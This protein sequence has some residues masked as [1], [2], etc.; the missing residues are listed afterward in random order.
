MITKK[1]ILAIAA[2]QNVNPVIIEKDYVLG[3]MLAGISVH[4]ILS[5]S[6][7]F[8][9]GTCIKKCYFGEY[10][11]SE[12]LDFTLT[13]EAVIDQAIVRKQ[14]EE[15]ID[16]LYEACGIEVPENEIDVFYDSND[17]T[18]R[19][20]LGYVGPL[21]QRGS[22]TRIKLDLTQNEFLVLP[23]YKSKIFHPYGD[24]KDFLYETQTYSYQEIF[25]EKIRALFERARP[26]D[27]Y[28]VVNLYERMKDYLVDRVVLKRIVQK[29]L[30][31]RKLP[32]L[33]Q[34]SLI[35]QSQEQELIQDWSSMLAHQLGHL[36]P[37]SAYLNKYPQIINWV[38]SDESDR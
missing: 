31:F 22:F 38:M 10:R 20:K 3:W 14:L 25:A 8:K 24:K 33:S 2:I 11:F 4:P 9:G 23:P 15:V 21:E 19:G 12:D 16:W 27:L 28:D 6:W 29:K 17:K 1:E 7:I 32:S 37:A 35:S 13:A 30:A 34:G 36:E 18:L 5:E 26:R